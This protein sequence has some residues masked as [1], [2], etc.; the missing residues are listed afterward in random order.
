MPNDSLEKSKSN[1]ESQLSV[2]DQDQNSD[3]IL[4]NGQFQSRVTGTG[5]VRNSQ[6]PCEVNQGDQDET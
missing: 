3:D 6:N 4:E 2:S 5:A 1:E